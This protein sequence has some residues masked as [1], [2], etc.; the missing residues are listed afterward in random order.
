MA[1]SDQFYRNLV[2]SFKVFSNRDKTGL[3][4]LFNP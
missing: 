1:T 4:A 3:F 2:Q